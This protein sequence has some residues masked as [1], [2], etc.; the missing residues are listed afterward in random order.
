MEQAF[1]K[2]RN[3][4]M[5]S[6]RSQDRSAAPD[7]RYSSLLPALLFGLPL[8][9]AALSLARLLG[10]PQVQ[11]YLSHPVE[12][13]EV[14][15]FCCA[16][17]ALGAKLW[18]WAAER[19]ACRRDVLPA[20]E[21]RPVPVGEAAEL[22][23]RVSQLPRRLRG[24]ALVKR[25][26]AVLDFLCRRGSAADLDDHCRAL[27][28]NDGVALENSYALT[29]FITWAIPIL[30]FL[31]TVLGIT[32]AIAG[33][34]PEKLEQDLNQVTDGLALAFD[35]TALALA[36]TM[37]V[38]F[39]TFVVDRL[40]QGVLEAVD[41]Y[42][43]RQLAHRFERAGAEAGGHAEALRQHSQ[44]LLEAMD[45]LVRRQAE[46]WAKTLDEVVYRR[47]EEERRQQE[48]LAEAF[49]AALAQTLRSHAQQAA[50]LQKQAVEGGGKL[51]EQMAAL[52]E[53]VRDTGREQQAALARVA[54]AVADQAKELAHLQAG[55]KQLLRLQETLNQNLAALAGAETFEQALHSL[56][57]AVHLLTVRAQPEP[58]AAKLPA[59]DHPGAAA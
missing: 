39:L 57:A 56:T 49:E 53:A 32:E 51:L 41:G 48:R 16:L 13:V 20:W 46:V 34:T 15:L 52:A 30:G 6:P 10:G 24:T 40:E 31:G 19:L 21:G 17:A 9:A 22:L 55:E 27:A 25:V 12:Q 33:V 50:A 5:T 4:D 43:D 28:D 38:M 8:A 14:V 47:A 37:V 35:C 29:R 3:P 11:R 58:R 59:R 18:R 2:P 26:A 42:V 36:L 45:Q 23:S 44:V 7:R 54:E 1:L